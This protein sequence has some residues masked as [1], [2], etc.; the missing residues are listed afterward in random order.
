MY[1]VLL[2]EA[3]AQPAG[4]GEEDADVEEEEVASVR[5]T[6]EAAFRAML[7]Q[8]LEEQARANKKWQSAKKDAEVR[9]MGD[10][11]GTTIAGG[12]HSVIGQ[13]T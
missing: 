2:P 3:A 4:E 1:S 8:V 7:G 11:H 12:L 10:R 13:S 5:R 9:G 6:A